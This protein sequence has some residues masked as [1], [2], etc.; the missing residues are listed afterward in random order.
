[1]CKYIFISL[2]SK[3]N[4]WKFIF[5]FGMCILCHRRCAEVVRRWS[6]NSAEMRLCTIFVLRLSATVRVD[7]TV[8]ISWELLWSMLACILLGMR[9]LQ[10]WRQ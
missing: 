6:V 7:L 9:W 10:F 5:F 1:L 8:E 2:A 3:E 4:L